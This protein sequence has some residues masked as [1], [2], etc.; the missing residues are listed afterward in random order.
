MGK[1]QVLCKKFGNLK[2]LK[3]INCSVFLF[4]YKKI[5]LEYAIIKQ[6]SP[7][8]EDLYEKSMDIPGRLGRP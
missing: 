1:I 5:P 8:K 7:G 6:N 4:L 3:R 2:W